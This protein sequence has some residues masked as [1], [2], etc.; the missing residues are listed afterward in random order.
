MCFVLHISI[1][2]FFGYYMVGHTEGVSYL[3]VVP[4]RSGTL[5]SKLPQLADGVEMD[6]ASLPPGLLQDYIFDDDILLDSAFLHKQWKGK[7][8]KSEESFIS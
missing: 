8:S 2:Q 6:P 5:K 7:F 1:S 4:R 3:R